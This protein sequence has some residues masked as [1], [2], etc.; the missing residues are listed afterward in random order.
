M[1]AVPSWLRAAAVGEYFAARMK[2]LNDTLWMIDAETEAS[3]GRPLFIKQEHFCY[4]QY[5]IVDG[6]QCVPVGTVYAPIVGDA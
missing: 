5:T 2:R 4:T 6:Q 3:Q 1:G